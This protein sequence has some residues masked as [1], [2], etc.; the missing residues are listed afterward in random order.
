ETERRLHQAMGEFLRGRTTLI[1]AHRLSTVE[2]AD[3]ILVLADGKI[4]EQGTHAEL[5][6]YGGM[7][8]SLYRSQLEPAE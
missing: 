8:T 3:R 7:Y 1:I 4:I 2:G 5:L 6:A